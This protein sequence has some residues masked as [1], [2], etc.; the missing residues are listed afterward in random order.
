MP[1]SEKLIAGIAL[2]EYGEVGTLAHT[3]GEL[4]KVLPSLR[5]KCVVA[6]IQEKTDLSVLME[7]L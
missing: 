7:M 5:S 1:I 2:P 6:G 3:Y 4:G